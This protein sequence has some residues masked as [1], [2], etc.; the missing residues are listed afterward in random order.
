MDD[1]AEQ[2]RPLTEVD[3]H[4]RP[5][6]EV[7]GP[8]ESV[9]HQ[10]AATEMDY[11][12]GPVSEVSGPPEA[13]A[14][15]ARGGL[16]LQARHQRRLQPPSGTLSPPTAV[17]SDSAFE[18]WLQSDDM[19]MSMFSLSEGPQ[20]S[21]PTVVALAAAAPVAEAVTGTRVF[22]AASSKGV[23]EAPVS[24]AGAASA[25][26]PAAAPATGGIVFPTASVGWAARA[27]A[28]ADA[29]VALTTA[30]ATGGIVPSATSVGGAP[31]SSAVAA[32]SEEILAAEP[33]A[34][35]TVPSAASIRGTV[36]GRESSTVAVSWD[37]EAEATP[38]T[39]GTAAPVA[40]A[41]RAARKLASAAGSAGEICGES[42]AS[43]HPFDPGTVF[44][45]EVRYS[46]DERARHN[47]SSGGSSSSSSNDNTND[48]ESWW[49]A[50]CVG[51]QLRL[52]DPGK[53]CRRRTRRGKAVL[54]MDLPS[55]RGKAWGRMQHGR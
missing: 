8:L 55:D 17:I 6:S 21:A 51:A 12:G 42:G 28:S 49:D 46:S 29:T 10:R 33:A 20:Q 32:A 24:S 13:T 47:S 37:A 48:H 18:D 41:A 44:P 4:G 34:S 35:G 23:A 22:P 3:Y 5:L 30:P 43:T 53:R 38:S 36:G 52:F 19:K 31:A 26:V 40:S 50:T 2:Q 7:F 15:L 25:A 9:E 45:L 1:R 27:P 14:S 39:V 16:P 54:G 11:H